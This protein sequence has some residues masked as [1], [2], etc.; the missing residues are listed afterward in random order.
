MASLPLAFSLLFASYA[1]S[2]EPKQNQPQIETG[3]ISE[4][5]QKQK[6]YR[7]GKIE[8]R[9][10]KYFD[11]QIVQP[12]IPFGSGAIVSRD[13]IASTIRDLYKLGYFSN[14][15]VYTRYTENGIDLTFAF[16]ELPVVQR[17]EFE[18]NKAISKEDLLK[19][20]EIDLSEKV[21]S[22]KPLPFSSI[23]PELQQKISSI[24]KGLGRVLSIDEITKMEKKLYTLYEKRGY[25]QTKISYY[26]RGN[27]LVFKIQEG[28]KAYV[29]QILINGN[30]AIKK[31]DIL[32][33]ME[34]SERSILKLKIHPPLV[35]ETLYEDI[36]KIRE[37][38]IKRGFF[39]VQ[40]DEPQITLERGNRYIITLNIK[41]GD[42]Y[43]LNSVEILNNDMFTKDEVLNLSKNM[44]L[45]PG[46]YYDGEK[47]DFIKKNIVEK[48]NDLGYL[49]ANVNINKI[50]DKEKKTV[51]VILDVQKGN[52]YYVD[53]VDISGN[54]ES[55]DA[56]VRREL[57]LAPGDLFLKDKLLRSQ[58]RLY[59]LGYYDMIGFDPNVKSEDEIDLS[60]QVNERF[61]GQ[62]SIGAG[63]SQQTGLSFFASL[64]KG[65][66]MG[67]GDTAGL[68][69]SLGS[70]YRNNSINYIHKWA[71]YKPLDL[72]LDLY[73]RYVNYSSFVSTKTG[74]SPTISFEFKEFWRT[75]I[76]LTLEK[77]EYKDVLG[78]A[79]YYI[80]RQAGKYD[81]Y[82]VYWFINRNSVNNPLLPTEGS[83]FTLT[84]KAGTGTRDFYKFV[85][86]GSKIIPDKLFYTD[87][88]FSV[89]ASVG[90]VETI[91][92]SIPLDELFFVGGDFT[93][94]GFG[95]GLA[96]PRDQDNNP[97]GAKRQIV[98]NNQISYPI[99]ERML[100]GFVFLDMGKG[101]DSGS[102]ISNLYRSV[103][104]G[105]KI[106]TPF[107]PIE[108][109]YGKV[110]NPPSG[111]DDSRF[112]FVLGTF[113]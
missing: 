28:A 62:I 86:S 40:I 79:S 5:Y 47:V 89:K 90:L 42:R 57:R 36:D 110:L 98:I 44:Q 95:W 54:Y 103:G 59:R 93:V 50:A 111:V 53:K 87:F 91:S 69:L 52:I 113:F 76:G 31:K 72:G 65:N 105:I 68:S 96:G 43:R 73:D 64:R 6:V 9:G 70:K 85:L 25:H 78:T 48:Y 33:V 75:G 55:R 27:T 45:K 77:G 1:F 107:A 67:T 17:V 82:S 2:E 61:S 4:E 112:G 104:G 81:L 99:V 12:I 74:F 58:A 11:P 63:F 102:P 100:W 84:L 10:L 3:T 83:D 60:T 8:I 22:G 108:L 14:I 32:S 35:K 19:E 23:G 38:Y 97:A 56:T 16:Q 39:D 18:G 30:K 26:Y 66:F 46:D 51:N 29:S 88:V 80:R 94:R 71:F 20:L 37:L 13:T 7:I 101:F 21:E 106:I 24:K 92:K 49:F 109:Y 34:T 41:E 15:E